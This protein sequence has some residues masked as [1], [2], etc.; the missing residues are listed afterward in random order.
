MCRFDLSFSRLP[1]RVL[2]SALPASGL[3]PS[4]V[5][6]SAPV[7]SF[8][9]PHPSLRRALLRPGPLLS[10]LR[11]APLRDLPP[12]ST[13]RPHGM[14]ATRRTRAGAAPC[15]SP[16]APGPPSL[17]CG[18]G[19]RLLRHMASWARASGGYPPHSSPPTRLDFPPSGAPRPSSLRHE[20]LAPRP[21]SP[22]LRGR[23][24]P[25][26]VRGPRRPGQRCALLSR[27]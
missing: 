3:P 25:P 18:R 19:R 6:C 16:G 10:S 15:A 9:A 8:P 5:H 23:W 20:Q 2:P 7:P 11:R 26:P 4:S 24:Q 13:L 14:R 21:P 12:S 22:P 17:R 27:G 1:P